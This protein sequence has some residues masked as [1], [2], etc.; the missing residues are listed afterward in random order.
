M[1]NKENP[2]AEQ[3]VVNE[4]EASEAS[5]SSAETCANAEEEPDIEKL[6]KALLLLCE[7]PFSIWE[8][9]WARE[10]YRRHESPQ[11]RIRRHIPFDNDLDL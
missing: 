7:V 8:R 6:R 9:V 3:C 4:S 11:G 10:W 2:S 1:D 5:G